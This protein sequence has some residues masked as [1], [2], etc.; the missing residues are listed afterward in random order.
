[1]VFSLFIIALIIFGF[2]YSGSNYSSDITELYSSFTPYMEDF[3]NSHLQA[4]DCE[5]R[6][7]YYADSDICFVCNG[8]HACFD[9]VLVNWE[10]GE[11]LSP[12]GTVR[13]NGDYDKRTELDF[14][15][16]GFTNGLDCDMDNYVCESDI[17][18]VIQ[19]SRVIMTLPE[20][21]DMRQKVGELA[22]KSGI[23]EC[24]FGEM[25][26]SCGYVDGTIYNNEVYI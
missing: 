6:N 4:I 21:T 14:H 23:G 15:S 10:H 2:Y 16:L 3:V 25:D 12:I 9:Y 18:V 19:N 26:F 22:E 24:E 5:P 13:L 1:M 8:I 7:Y 17:G 20:E 11:E